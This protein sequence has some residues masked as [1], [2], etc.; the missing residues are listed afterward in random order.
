MGGTA[1]T[2]RVTFE[3]DENENITVVKG[4]RLSEN[5]I[6]RM[7]EASPPGSKSPRYSGGYGASVSEE[8]LK[9]RVAEE[10]ALQ[11][12]KKDL[13]KQKRL[14]QGK[15]ADWEQTS[16]DE[17]LTR[18]ILRERLNSEAERSNAKH[19]EIE[20][21]AKQLEE[22]DRLIKKQDEF[23]KEQLARLEERSSEFYK[24]TTEQYQKAVE[25][26]E[27]KFKR[28]DYHPVCA[29]LQARILQCY[30]QN[31]HETLSCSALAAQ[32]MHC[33]NQAKQ[34]SLWAEDKQL[35]P[36]PASTAS[37][38]RRP[39]LRLPQPPAQLRG[40]RDSSHSSV[41]PGLYSLSV[42]HLVSW[43]SIPGDS[44]WTLGSGA[45]SSEF[46]QTWGVSPQEP[47][48]QSSG[49]RSPDSRPSSCSQV[50]PLT[51]HRDPATRQT[52][53]QTHPGTPSSVS[54]TRQEVAMEEG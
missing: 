12:A 49:A 5:V 24:V 10:L 39:A 14:K 8:D 42:H 9:A 27:A 43:L 28:Y 30:R 4:I 46:Y 11:Q 25:E 16:A 2:R 19:L 7:K 53:H 31:T 44:D 29:D 6:D 41:L 34:I 20:D 50:L 21:K 52:P 26:V 18:A 23:Y 15:E 54:R 48:N 13:E 1:S 22:K 17:R 36:G 3:A 38:C 33:V 37:R 35:L 51:T 45:R 40:S 47:E 32:Y